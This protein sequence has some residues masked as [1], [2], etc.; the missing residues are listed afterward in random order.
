VKLGK[1][2][3][4]TTSTSTPWAPAQP[5]LT[6]AGNQ[7]LQTAQ[8]NQGNLNNIESGL[9]GSILPGIQNL[10]SSGQQQM[11]PGMNYLSSVLGGNY[12]NENNASVQQMAKLAGQQA[13]NQ[14]DS[15]FGAAGRTGS[16]ANQYAM[17]KGVAAGELAPMLQNNQFEQGLQQQAAGMLPSYYASQFSGYS[18]LLQGTQLAGQLPYYGSQSLNGIGSLYSGYGTGTQTQPGGWMNGL[19]NAGAQIG[20]AAIMASDR[21]LKKNIVLLHRD[22]DGLGWYEWE[23]KADSSKARGVIADEVKALRPWAYVPNFRDGY[24]GVNYAK[25]QEAA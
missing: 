18:P 14:V 15:T 19:L 4:K 25:L 12:L 22:P 7:I 1:K 24:D 9:T 8:N 23:W 2:S 17:A 13:A 16:N 20:S 21:R 10:I 5:I 3:T 6:G 11:Q